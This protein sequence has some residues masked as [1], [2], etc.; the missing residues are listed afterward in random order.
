[1][2]PASQPATHR[3][4]TPLVATA[5]GASS[6]HDYDDDDDDQQ[7][8]LINRMHFFL[9]NFAASILYPL[10]L[11]L[12]LFSLPFGYH[13]NSQDHLDVLLLFGFLE[14]R[15]FKLGGW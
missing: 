10:L 6:P 13:S 2:K 5:A 9:V 4:R 8:Q 12:S 1:L 11:S 14:M 7:Q 3:L 15:K